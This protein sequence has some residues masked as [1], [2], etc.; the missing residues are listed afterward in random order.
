MTH[1]WGEMFMDVFFIG[2]ICA[3]LIL[4]HPKVGHLD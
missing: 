1:A 2:L 4:Y 3:F